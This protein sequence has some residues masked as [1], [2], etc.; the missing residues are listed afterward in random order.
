MTNYNS[1]NVIQYL[2]QYEMF[3][4]SLNL[5]KHPEEKKMIIKQLTKLEYKIID[6]TNETYEEEY[7]TLLQ[8]ECEL[9]DDEK[10]RLMALIDL[11]NQ[12]LSYVEKRCNNHYQ[13]TGE[14]LDVTNVLGADTL[15][16]LENK[17]KIIEKYQKN[18]KLLEELQSDIENLTSKIALAS[19]KIDI[20]KK[21]NVELE[22]KFKESISSALEKNHL[23]SL[24]ES[25][26][27]I[28]S[29]YYE[30]EKSLTLAELNLESAK[31]SP[32]DVLS[33]CQEIFDE[34]KEDYNKYK[35]KLS[36]LRL[37]EIFNQDVNNYDELLKKRREVNELFKYIKNDDFVD[38][39]IDMVSKQYN[40][41]LM[42][43]QDIDTFEDLTLEK[44][45]K[46]EAIEEIKEE[47]ESD[48]FQ[49]ILKK[50]IEN[51]KKHAEKL[52]EERQ[53]IEEIEKKKKLELERK[54]QE[55]ILKRQKIIEAARKKEME[56]RTKEMLEQQQ[57]SVLQTN[58]HDDEYSFSNMREDIA[59]S[60]VLDESFSRIKLHENNHDND[61]EDNDT[62]KK[63]NVEILKNK[64]DIEKELFDEFNNSS[65][66]ITPENTEQ[67]FNNDVFNEIEEENKLPDISIDEYMKTFDASKISDNDDFFSTNND[68]PSIPE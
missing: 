44:N 23:Y 67:L 30:T 58:K 46:M 22:S 68:F 4:N 42:E 28:E 37:M 52:Q 13:L 26:E 36:L 33:E 40:T 64:Q 38:M 49:Q 12:R 54:K 24:L 50:L 16:S 27:E 31:T 47:N 65:K 20:N 62:E 14:T 48:E 7:K 45:R 34:V 5:V 51:E 17:V 18:V 11:I 15:D 19:K 29:A 21:L 55:E 2:R 6:I 25:K 41:I 56:K 35:D 39:I 43:Q 60:N 66:K 57:N 1:S 53:R 9:F 8:K 59:D 61:V 63:D 10:K 32:I 3:S